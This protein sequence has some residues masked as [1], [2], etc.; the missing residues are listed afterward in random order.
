M[1]GLSPDRYRSRR[2]AAS[3]SHAASAPGSGSGSTLSSNCRASETRWSGGRPRLSLNKDSSVAVIS[4]TKSY[5]SA[6]RKPGQRPVNFGFSRSSLQNHA[7]AKP[8]HSPCPETP[9]STPKSISS[10]GPP[11]N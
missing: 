8:P 11:K 4:G 7:L 6:V 2:R 10:T 1:E 3:A 9:T 5:I